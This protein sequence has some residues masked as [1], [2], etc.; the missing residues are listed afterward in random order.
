MLIDELKYILENYGNE[1]RKSFKENVLGNKIRHEIP[2]ILKEIYSE[3]NFFIKGSIGQ[4]QWADCPWICIFDKTIS[5]KTTEGIYIAIL[6]KTD[7]TGFYLAV[8]QGWTYFKKRYPLNSA[9]NKIKNTSR[10]LIKLLGDNNHFNDDIDL[11]SKAG[12]N[13]EGYELGTVFSKYYDINS[14]PSNCVLLDDIQES[15]NLL[16]EISK[17][18][19]TSRTF[20]DFYT[21]ILLHEEKLYLDDVKDELI[22]Q[23]GIESMQTIKDCTF[24]AEQPTLVNVNR[25]FKSKSGNM[26]WLRNSNIAAQA[27][28]LSKNQ[29]AID[30]KH[31]SFISR[32]TGRPYMEAHH[33]IPISKQGEFN[34]ELDK[35]ANIKCL[36]PNCH[37]AIHFG[38]KKQRDKMIKKLYEDSKKDL[39]KL[40]LNIELAKL[41]GMY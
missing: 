4:G 41:L 15:M 36:C 19:G 10:E 40:G 34:Y 18:I 26:N 12:S 21:E 31:T 33:L 16:K 8:N 32:K 7:M 29:C 3:N 17:L 24:K 5:K 9:R 23:E 13:A 39:E 25:R 28:L 22:Y 20:E 35:V 1:K 2:N 38:E 27:I 37:R 11:I 6:F 14:L 30:S